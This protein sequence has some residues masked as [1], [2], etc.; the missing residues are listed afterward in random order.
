MSFIISQRS[1]GFQT[2][3]AA[4][5][6]WF[7]PNNDWLFDVIRAF[8]FILK[9]CFLSSK[10]SLSSSYYSCEDL[11]RSNLTGAI[12]YEFDSFPSFPSFLKALLTSLAFCSEGFVVWIVVL[13]SNIP[14]FPSPCLPMSLQL[15]SCRVSMQPFQLFM[16]IAHGI[17]TS[18][19]LRSHPF[20]QMRRLAS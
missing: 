17:T 2:W 18:R 19:S 5:L 1:C 7:R 6:P 16:F 3:S 20:S 8:A 13:C 10:K 12:S 11:Q 14:S 9:I 4:M 15:L